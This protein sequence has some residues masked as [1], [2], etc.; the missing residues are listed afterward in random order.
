MSAFRLTLWAVMALGQLTAWYFWQKRL[1]SLFLRSGIKTVY[2][3][4]NVVTAAAV[5]QLYGLEII[6]ADHFLWTVL[7]RPSLVWQ[8]GHLMWLVLAS[9]VWITSFLSRRWIYRQP[10]GLP[11]L[12][13]APRSGRPAFIL[14]LLLWFLTLG[15][16]GYAYSVQLQPA[17]VR[18]YTLAYPDL[19]PRLEGLKI[20]HLSDLHYGL[21]TDQ[22][23]LARR[24]AETAALSPDLILITGDLI[25]TRASLARDWR[26]P[27]QSLARVPYGVYAVLGNHDLYTGN[28]AEESR[29]FESQGL[30]VLRNQLSNIPGLPLSLIGLDD[31]GTRSVFF[32]PD[33]NSA[34]LDFQAV[35]GL[36][37]PEGNFVILFRHRPQ[38]LESAAQAGVSLYLAGHTHGGQFQTPWNSR[39]N[40]MSLSSDYTEGLYR[41]GPVS[42]IISNGLAAAGL[43]FRLWAWPEIGLIT[44]T[45]G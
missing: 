37:V 7:Y 28:P 22:A 2:L 10:R 32:R 19:P 33:P 45:R 1:K 16:A 34:V 30:T 39:W 18:A 42:L 27:L 36:P 8:F 29:I 26:E 15:L 17:R 6:P 12:F 44:L 20:A 3:L 40:L 41:H 11:R 13:R 5:V 14:V 23:E 25:D 21:G 35:K 43:P 38:G 24:L 31:P 4:I 9:G